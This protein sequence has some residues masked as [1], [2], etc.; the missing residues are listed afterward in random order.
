MQVKL[1]KDPKF[2]E[3]F[4]GIPD[5]LT[6]GKITARIT[7]LMLGNPGN[8]EGVGEGVVELKIDYGP[9]WRVYYVKVGNEIIVLLG[10]GSK[11]QQQSDIDA[12]KERAKQYKKK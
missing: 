1:R 2:D 6:K 9:G 7:R 3:F 8:T 11:K 4:D 5:E 10:G 12:A